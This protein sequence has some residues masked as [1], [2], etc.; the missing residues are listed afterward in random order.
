MENGILIDYFS[1]VDRGFFGAL[2]D[3]LAVATDF[4]AA[5]FLAGVLLD[6]D[7]AFDPLTTFSSGFVSRTELSIGARVTLDVGFVSD[8]I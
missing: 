2:V 6:T 1:V 7:F 8:P 4:L 3:F 5:G